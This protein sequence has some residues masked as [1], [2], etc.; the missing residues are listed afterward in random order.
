MILD[1]LIFLAVLALGVALI[2]K[3]SDWL[4]DS[5]SPVARKLGTSNT[6]VAL[7]LVSFLVSL[8]EV[9]VALFAVFKGYPGISIGMIL[10]SVVANIG[11]MAGLSAMIRPLNVTRG[12]ILRDGV[13]A[14]CVMIMV[15]VLSM[16]GTISQFQGFGLLLMFIPYI[17]NVWEQERTRTHEEKQQQLNE[18]E[19]ELDIIGGIHHGHLKAGVGTFLAGIV[20]LLIGAELFSR[21]LID[22]AQLSGAPQILIGLTLG[23]IGTTIPNIAAALK[24]TT[25]KMEHIAVTETLGSNVF[26]LL[27][28]L[29]IVSVV[30]PVTILPEWLQVTIPAMLIMGFAFTGFMITQNR[31]SRLEGSALFFGYI[32]I[33][34]I[35]ILTHI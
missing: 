11:L 12:M 27:V 8:P 22:I 29:G 5:L 19:H 32:A 3:G 25:R 1:Y 18:V 31:I 26:T 23:A 14:L 24:A 35:E 7:L 10:G 30:S 21:S 34:I 6:A 16:G 2:S 15:A 33:L 28:T 4:T 9:L 17:I 13:F 20:L